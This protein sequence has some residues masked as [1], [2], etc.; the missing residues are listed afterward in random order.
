M[1]RINEHAGGAAY[2][3]DIFS[4]GW[5]GGEATV[6]TNLPISFSFTE[7]GKLAI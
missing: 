6:K 4:K 5:G 7:S 3:K 2:G 1:T